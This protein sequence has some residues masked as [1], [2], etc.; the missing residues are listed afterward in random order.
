MPVL[1]ET[2]GD[3]FPELTEK[4]SYVQEVILDEEMSFNRILSLLLVHGPR[5]SGKRFEAL[6]AGSGVH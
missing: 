5:Y 2:M 4:V 3:V 6:P 1:V